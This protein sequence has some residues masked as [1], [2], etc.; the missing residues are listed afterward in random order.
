MAETNFDVAERKKH[1][2]VSRFEMLS[3]ESWRHGLI[4]FGNG[5]L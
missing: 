2:Y 1:V 5:D 3:V 4:A